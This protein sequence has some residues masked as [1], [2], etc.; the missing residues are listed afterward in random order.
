MKKKVI[1]LGEK[2]LFF[3]CLKHVLKEKNVKL[4]GICLPKRDQNYWWNNQKLIQFIKKKKIKK[5][6]SWNIPKYKPDIIISILFPKI[7]KKEI[8]KSSKLAINLHQAPLPDYRGCNCASHAIINGAKKFGSTLHI[9]SE[10]LDAGD[11]IAQKFFKINEKI[12]AKELY[13]QNDKVALKLFK[14]NFEKILNGKFRTK[15]IKSKTKIYQRNSL[16]KI[17]QVKISELN[18]KILNTIRGLEFYPHEPAFVMINKVK[19][20]LLTKPELYNEKNN[21]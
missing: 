6:K 16:E 19:V 10:E 1:L 7:L 14:L 18:K 17:K 5:I 11:I 4:L 12:I 15:K 8:I 9:L 3:D 2:K 20:Y 13:L 21:T